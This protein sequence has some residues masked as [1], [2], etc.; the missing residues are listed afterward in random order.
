MELKLIGQILRRGS[1][2]LGIGILFGGGLG[3]AVSVLQTHVDGERTR[4]CGRG[5]G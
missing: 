3:Y 4:S 2:V 5:A 1:G